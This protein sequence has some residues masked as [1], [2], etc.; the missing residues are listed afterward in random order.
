MP[1]TFSSNKNANGICD[2]CGFTY[3]LRVLRTERVN[4]VETN[5]LVCP[6]CWDPDHPQNMQGRIDYSD[7]QALRNPRV[8]TWQQLSQFG[9]SI[10]YE[11]KD[12]IQDFQGSNALSVH[13]A[14]TGTVT[15]TPLGFGNPKFVRNVNT[16]VLNI[17]PSIY[18]RI[19]VRVREITPGGWSGTSEFSADGDPTFINGP[20]GTT[21]QFNT[22]GDRWVN[23][24]WDMRGFWENYTD[25]QGVRL[26]LNE[27]T[28][29]ELEIDYI[30]F[31]RAFG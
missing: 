5:L 4:L 3:K 21:P 26:G 17:D 25:I 6:T 24:I 23:V 11:F 2:R 18:S 7:P 19:N 8:D 27:I 30:R 20:K 10:R 22:M 12:S 9:D 13:S 16:S 29:S 15:L 1:G 14:S 28:G 31:E